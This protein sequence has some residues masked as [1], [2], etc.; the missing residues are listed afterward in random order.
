MSGNCKNLNYIELAGSAFQ[1]CYILL[2]FC[3]FILLIFES[4]IFKLQFKILIYLFK[5]ITATYSGTIYNFVL[6]FPSLL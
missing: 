6:Y 3:L 1:V 4:L 2:L 5:K